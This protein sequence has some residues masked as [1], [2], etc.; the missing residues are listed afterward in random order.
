MKVRFNTPVRD[1]YQRIWETVRT[2]PRGT[3]ATY[4]EV[5]RL[6]GMP[7]Q[8]RLTGYALHNLPPGSDI[9]W[10]RVINAKGMISLPRTTG[11]HQRQRRKLEEEG[12]VFL[13]GKVNLSRQGWKRMRPEVRR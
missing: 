13:K 12:V 1:S 5:A 9:P 4:G 7:G 3:V 6:S 10:H 11:A 8:A 2:I